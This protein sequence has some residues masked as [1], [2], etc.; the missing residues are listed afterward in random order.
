MNQ[1]TIHCTKSGLHVAG[2]KNVGSTS[3]NVISTR[4]QFMRVAE[5]WWNT[6]CEDGKGEAVTPTHNPLAVRNALQTLLS[7]CGRM[8]HSGIPECEYNEIVKYAKDALT[9]P[10]RICD[11]MDRHKAI[12]DCR[13]WLKIHDYHL[14]SKQDEVM[15]QT[16]WW[17]YD[18]TKNAEVKY[19]IY[20]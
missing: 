10:A 5:H 3:D 7:L 8:K 6:Y 20:A 2:A 1:L 18:E 12:Y 9:R 16:I 13:T 17:L 19:G 11:K 15:M 4:S 14:S